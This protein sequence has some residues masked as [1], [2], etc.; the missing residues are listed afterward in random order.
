M[1][2][3][4]YSNELNDHI[5]FTSEIINDVEMFDI[6]AII[7]HFNIYNKD[8]EF[9]MN[10]NNDTITTI[11][12]LT[13]VS[14]E[15]IIGET[16]IIK[17]DTHWHIN[18]NILIEYLSEIKPDLMHEIISQISYNHIANIIT[19]ENTDDS[20]ESEDLSEQSED[21]EDDSEQDDDL[22][23]QGEDI[24]EQSEELSE[25]S[26]EL[27]EQSEDAEDDSE[28]SEE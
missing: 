28:Q 20:E 14:D 13:S 18:M 24:S 12:N 19:E 22:S 7:N 3:T 27:S 10:N 5:T 26:E 15:N 23:E 21:M 9:W 16:T 25:Q 2:Y 17:I 4:V 1:E 11:E 8:F 6:T